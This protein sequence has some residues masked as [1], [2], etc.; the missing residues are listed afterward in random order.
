MLQKY[1]KEAENGQEE[2]EKSREKTREETRAQFAE[3]RKAL[4]AKEAELLTSVDQSAT[5]K[6]NNLQREIT[7]SKEHIETCTNMENLIYQ[8]T[9]EKDNIK[10]GTVL[11]NLPV[12]ISLCCNSS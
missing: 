9:D 11:F 12:R 3:L 10:V 1:I 5:N 6:R 2:L 4:D 7:K 8:L